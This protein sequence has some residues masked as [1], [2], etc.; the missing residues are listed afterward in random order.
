MKQFVVQQTPWSQVTAPLK[1]PAC[2]TYHSARMT[3]EVDDELEA[4][5]QAAELS[6]EEDATTPRTGSSWAVLADDEKESSGGTQ[7]LQ[8]KALVATSR[9]VLWASRAPRLP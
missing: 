2:L 1:K 8:R 6:P 5:A 3:D 7:R 9:V 4:L